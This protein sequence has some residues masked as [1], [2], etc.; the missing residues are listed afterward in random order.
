MRG[1]CR[2]QDSGHTIKAWCDGCRRWGD[3]LA[4]KSAG[5]R[6]REQAPGMEME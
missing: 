1:E 6:E 3:V 2:G 5:D 4:W